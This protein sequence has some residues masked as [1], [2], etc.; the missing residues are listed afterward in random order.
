MKIFNKDINLKNYFCSRDNITYINNGKPLINLYIQL[1]PYCN[2]KCYFCD[3]RNCNNIFDF[4][5]FKLIIEELDE[6][7]HLGKIA[8][9]G[10][11]P[12]LELDKIIKIIDNYKDRYLTLNTNAYDIEK[13]K[14]IY[15]YF[16]EVHISKHHFDNNKND[17]I[18]KIKTPTLFDL[19]QNNLVKNTKIN[20][21]FQKGYMETKN[22]IV[23]MMEKMSLYQLKELRCISLLPLTQE[24][25]N[26][27]VC[28]DDLMKECEYFMNDDYLYDKSHCKCFEFIYIA[29]NGQ[30]I[31]N[32]I[33]QTYNDNYSCVKQLVY[34]GKYLYDGFKKNNIIF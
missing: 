11:E 9:T 16:K 23:Q 21:V 29:N 26:H 3:T 7:I 22:D 8:I 32:L 10:G 31:K 33:R 12:L 14:M 1:T 18:M 20:C 34:D 13:L 5:K 27:Y 15:S 6:K 25:I 4:E 30:L 19:Y 2:A 17:E 24:G 28:L